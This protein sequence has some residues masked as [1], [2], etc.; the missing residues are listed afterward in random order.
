MKRA[1]MTAEKNKKRNNT[2][3]LLLI[4]VA[5]AVAVLLLLALIGG[6]GPSSEGEVT[7]TIPEGATTD[8]IAVMLIDEQV[9]SDKDD[10]LDKAASAGIDQELQAGKYV[11]QRGEP[12]ED[13]LNK[14]KQGLQDPDAV[15]VIPEGY[16]I[17]DIAD[18]VA[19]QTDVSREAYLDAIAVNGRE[20]PL[21]GTSDALDMEGFLFPSTYNIGSSFDVDQFVDE[22]LETFID[23]TADV[24]WEKAA[25]LGITEYEALI[26]ASMV[27]R[28]AR[29]DEER[30]L[31][32]A[33]I[34]NR[35]DAGMKLEIDATV[36]YALGYWK[37]ELTSEDLAVDS[38]FNTRLYAGIPPGPICNPG[39]ESINAALNPA[40]VD[41]LY[42]VATGD[43]AGTHTFTDSYE[44]FLAAGG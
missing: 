28:E 41:Y 20:L 34:D 44:E 2:L 12:V 25:E 6:S 16:S 40:S 27:E 38:L 5:A 37:E 10:F 29:V 17:Y 11:F 18:L 35:I 26:I 36:Q 19:E 3:L 4:L 14:L 43:D 8:D 13:I 33:V 1:E 30:P 42:Y 31:V 9:I 32:A 39:I 23:E 21:E 15:L 22:Q 24:E 7:L